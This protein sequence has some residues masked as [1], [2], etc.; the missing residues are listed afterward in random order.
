MRKLSNSGHSIFPGIG[1][2]PPHSTNPKTLPL[3]LRMRSCASWW[4]P[5]EVASHFRTGCSQHP[6]K[7]WCTWNLDQATLRKKLRHS[8]SLCEALGRCGVAIGAGLVLSYLFL[9]VNHMICCDVPFKSISQVIRSIFNNTMVS[10]RPPS[11][12]IDSQ[13]S[14]RVPIS[15][16][17]SRERLLR[18]PRPTY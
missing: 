16:P 7:A 1:R 18:H 3:P 11:P 6:R 9:C 17:C 2:M 8:D 15:T 14:G 10:L 4:I 5:I 12:L 13:L